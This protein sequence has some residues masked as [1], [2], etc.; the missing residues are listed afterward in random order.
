MRSHFAGRSLTASMVALFFAHAAHAQGI[1]SFFQQGQF[2]QFG[3]QRGPPSTQPTSTK[4]QTQDDLLGVTKTAG[5]AFQSQCANAEKVFTLSCT[6]AFDGVIGGFD[7]VEGRPLSPALA[8]ALKTLHIQVLSHHTPAAID[9]SWKGVRCQ[10][11]PDN[12]Q[13]SPHEV[14]K[15]SVVS[16]GLVRCNLG[17][18]EW[19]VREMR[20]FNLP[21]GPEIGA[22]AGI[23]KGDAGNSVTE[24]SFR[25]ALVQRYGEKNCDISNPNEYCR[26]DRTRITVI[27]AESD[28]PNEADFR[29]TLSDDSVK[30]R[31]LSAAR[32]RAQKPTTQAPVN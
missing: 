12:V 19:R 28:N 1:G 29:V 24:G 11:S 13:W 31:A 30:D 18:A 8:S 22:I 26:A 25:A 3:P 16:F 21:G 10:L 15:D 14:Q 5:P 9:Q 23:Y 7:P 2:V 20:I 17:N 32:E 27:P 6:G 4:T